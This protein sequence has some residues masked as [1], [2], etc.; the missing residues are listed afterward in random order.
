M[1]NPTSQI[2]CGPC[3]W[4]HIETTAKQH[5]LE[6][7]AAH[8]DAVEIPETFREFLRPEVTRVWLRK[9]RQN[10]EF[11]FSAKLHL[12]FTHDRVLVP[13]EVAAFKDGLWPL[14]RAGRLGCVL[15]QFPWSFR[16]TRENREHFINL[17]RTFHEFP[18]VAEM[19]HASWMVDEAVGTF[20]D[21]RVGFC[22]IDQPSYTRAM[23]PTAFL[24]SGTGYVRLH[25]RNSFNWYQDDRAPVQN[26]RYDYLYSDS[27]LAEW[28]A[29]VDRIAGFASKVF[30]I[31]NNDAGGKA[32]VNGLQL[33]SMLRGG[34]GS[35][36][37][38]ELLRR[39]PQRSQGA[40][41]TSYYPGRAV[42]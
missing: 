14:M 17:R 41:F 2:L 22:N 27:E 34:D 38:Q 23:P 19:R 32:V 25:G 10:T 12:R 18:L 36:L 21:Y 5:P 16:Y 15:M 20:I 8:F 42:A 28:K 30:V 33:R 29:R 40:L 7:V 11:Q 6:Y 39:Y 31:T 26:H 3:G 4:S 9:V 35:D 24:T 37:P 1:S 13:E